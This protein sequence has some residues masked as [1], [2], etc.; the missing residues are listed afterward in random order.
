[1]VMVRVITGTE[2]GFLLIL[3]E[4]RR[5]CVLILPEGGRVLAMV[6]VRVRIRAS[7]AVT[8]RV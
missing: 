5:A 4:G 8:F 6:M 1:M 2:G 7:V 3:P